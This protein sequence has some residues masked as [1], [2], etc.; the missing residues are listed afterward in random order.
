MDYIYGKNPVTELIRSPYPIGEIF[1]EGGPNKKPFYKDLLA[2][3]RKSGKQVQVSYKSRD[4][5][6]RL[7]GNSEHQGVAAAFEGFTVTELDDFLKKTATTKDMLIFVLDCIHDPHNVGAIVRSSYAMGVSA[8][9][10][11]EKRSAKINSTVA[12]TSSGALFH[13]EIVRSEGIFDALVKLKKAGFT[14]LGCE[15][16]AETS[17][18]DEKLASGKYAVVLGNEGEGISGKSSS[19]LDRGVKIPMAAPFDSL[20]VS[21]TAGIIAYEYLRQKA[22][23]K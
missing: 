9:V 17:I 2:E 13:V 3:L 21:V 12:K 1:L 14:V 15:M 6:S 23:A 10:V 19:R 7:T 20:N 4:L 11:F 5:I 16:E 8:C 18:F 22:A